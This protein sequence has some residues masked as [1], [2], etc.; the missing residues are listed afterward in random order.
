[1]VKIIHK[2]TSE[3]LVTLADAD[4]WDAIR[5]HRENEELKRKIKV[6]RMAMRLKVRTQNDNA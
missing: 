6:Y 1:M 3:G 4:T 2:L 5:L